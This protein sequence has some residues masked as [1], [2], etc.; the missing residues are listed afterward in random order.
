MAKLV[1][2]R[3]LLTLMLFLGW[4]M[5]L[6]LEVGTRTTPTGTSNIG[7]TETTKWKWIQ[8]KY[9]KKWRK[10]RGRDKMRDKMRDKKQ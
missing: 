10:D 6:S 1:G 3:K 7:N 8:S 4:E 5:L 2:K 9:T